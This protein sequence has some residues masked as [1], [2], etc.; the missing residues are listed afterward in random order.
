MTRIVTL[1]LAAALMLPLSAAFAADEEPSLEFVY[2]LITKRAVVERELEFKLRHEKGREGRQ[3]ELSA[4]LEYAL[5]PRWQIEL[6][7]P[8]IFTDP[9]E[10]A[11]MAGVGDIAIENKFLF[12]RSLERKAQAVVGLE[13]TLPTGSERRGLGGEAAVEPFIAGAIALGDFDVLGS[14]AYPFNVNAH[15]KGPREQ[16]LEAGVAVG[17]RLHRRFTPLLELTTVTRTR[18]DDEDGLLHR[19]QVYLTPGFNSRLWPGTTLRLGIQLPVS[20]AH[21]FDYALHAGF[22]KEF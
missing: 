10:G 17:Y 4:G 8:V 2:P 22:V 7:V 3:T 11:A 19:T 12:Y 16:A 13:V 14:A 21:A 20:D 9:R 18:G 1:V 6:E 15:V 5:L